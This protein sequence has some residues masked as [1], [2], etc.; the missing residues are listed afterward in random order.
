VSEPGRSF[1]TAAAAY[2]RYRPEYAD[3]A[4]RW[5]ADRLRL[6]PGA[7]VLDLG[8]GTGKLTR[9]L[10]ARGFDVVAVEPG[11]AMLAQLR[12][13][14]PGV[15]ALAGS[16][17]AIPLP[18]ASVDA[19]AAGQAYHWFDAPHA[20]PELLRVLRPH[21]GLG[22]IWNWEDVRH[23]LGA[24]LAE[25]LGHD[26]GFHHDP[27]DPGDFEP[28]DQAVIETIVSTTPD[29]LVGWI[30]TTSQLLTADPSR[31][32]DLLARVRRA[33]QEYGETV[34]VPRLTY[35]YAYRAVS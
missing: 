24:R 29:G 31:R 4:L 33:G 6:E 10:V 30:G 19:V 26:G 14:V 21:G 22:L 1:E 23:P 3:A 5:I 18:D 34:P 9:G 20:L 16:A 17:E 8:A 7:R 35:V 32:E 15:E 2:E 25:I 28:V 11:E 12:A 27:P 13:A